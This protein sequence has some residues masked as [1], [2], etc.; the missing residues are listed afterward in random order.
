MSEATQ[1]EP[2]DAEREALIA[3]MNTV[4]DPPKACGVD[5]CRHYAGYLDS[6]DN[7]WCAC[8]YWHDDHTLASECEGQPAPV[9]PRRERAADA[10]LAAGFRRPVQTEPTDAQ[11]TEAVAALRKANRYMSIENAMRA[12]LRAARA[13]GPVFPWAVENRVVKGPVIALFRTKE[14]AEDYVSE[15]LDLRVRPVEEVQDLLY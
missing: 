11:V 14:E 7:E 9:P 1:G 5:G 3:V 13:A 15:F 4:T 8:H 6:G 10:I 2:T 12:A